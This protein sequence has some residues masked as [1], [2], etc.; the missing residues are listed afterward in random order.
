MATGKEFQTRINIG[1]KFTGAQAFAA[2]NRAINATERNAKAASSRMH[3]MFGAVQDSA[4]KLRGAVMLGGAALGA[5]AVSKAVTSIVTGFQTAIDAALE[6]EKTHE[7]LGLTLDQTAK[8]WGLN[9]KQLELQKQAMIALGERISELG[10]DAETLQAMFGEVTRSVDPRA[11]NKYSKGLSDL[12]Y[13]Q[14]GV[15]AS[16]E[17]AAEL[18][19]DVAKIIEYKMPKAL[20]AFKGVTEEQI[21]AYSKLETREQRELWFFRNIAKETGATERAFATSQ[22]RAQK[23]R[24]MLEDV[25]E[26]IG[27]PFVALRAQFSETGIAILEKLKP[28]IDLFGEKLQES[29]ANANK[30][31]NEHQA[32]V[33]AALDKIGDAII[34]VVDHWKEFT[35]AIG[36]VAVFGTVAVAI[37]AVTLALGAILSPIGLVVAAL[38]GLTAAGV[39]IYSHWDELS[40][41]AVEL[42][43]KIQAAWNAGV[44]A[45]SEWDFG[46]AFEAWRRIP[47]MI[48]NEVILKIIDYFWGLTEPI[49]T[50][51]AGVYDAIFAPFKRVYDDIVALFANL[52]T[53]ISNAVSGAWSTAKAVSE[54]TSIPRGAGEAP[55]LPDVRPEY[56]E[57]ALRVGGGPTTGSTNLASERARLIAEAN[58]PRVRRLLKERTE[59]EVGG[60]GPEAQTAFMESVLNRAAARR[61]SL[62]QTLV[63]SYWGSRLQGVSQSKSAA[64][65]DVIGRVARG[66]N[67]ARLA[68]GNESAGLRS[69]GGRARVHAAIRGERFVGEVNK[70]DLEW[71]RRMRGGEQSLSSTIE[72]IKP[73]ATSGGG[74]TNTVTSTN[75]VTINGVDTNNL[76]AVGETV[77]MALRAR[78]KDLLTQLRQAKNAEAR[79]AYV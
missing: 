39:A 42:W 74:P 28:K 38:A 2:A 30:W 71:I 11:L 48:Y 67:V 36:A 25:A 53:I 20:K 26:T 56:Y 57:R 47:E 21:K 16:E 51:V 46:A 43:D 6:V 5:V 33:V 17:D 44:A 9:Q 22:G 76:K 72:G 41:K 70:A 69:A 78:D 55:N 60:Q 59:G 34:F 49:R 15:N 45:I 73:G 35:I 10:P 14:K 4:K 77:T 40:G 18:G 50:A 54:G 1:A 37:A 61:Q 13:T 68:T 62:A 7:K 66:S 65:E 19:S 23:F 29:L 31:W 3:K 79:L 8:R 63:G 75:P 64:Y 12:L 52:G 58:D 27:K 32:Q 24:N